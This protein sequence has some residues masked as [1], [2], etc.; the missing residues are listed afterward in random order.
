VPEDSTALPPES[1]SPPI[2]PGELI[3]ERYLV[4]EVLGGGGMGVVYAGTHVLLGTPVAIKLIHPE[5]KDDAEA[6]GRFVNEARAAAA[7]KG[8][9]IA[10]V[11]DAGQLPTGEPYLVMEQ[12]AGVSLDQYLQ[13]RG[14]LPQAEAVAIVLQ[15]CE[16]LAEAHATALVHRDIKPANVFLAERPDGNYSVKVIDFGIAKQRVRTDTPALTNPGKSLGSPW[17]MSP[18]QMLTPASVDPRADIWSLGVLLFELLTA[19]LPFDGESV[20]QVCANVLSTP[21]PSPSE[22]R[23]DVAPELD[24]IVHRC[25][26]KEPQKRFASVNDLAQALL[27]FASV[28]SWNDAG[29]L[30]P[31]AFTDLEPVIEAHVPAYD[32]YT[33]LH[34]SHDVAP[35]PQ[36]RR[37]GWA[38]A[39]TL[40]ALASLFFGGY[41]QYRDPTLVRRAVNATRLTMPWDPT[42]ASA[43][44]PIPLEPTYESPTLLQ[45]MHSSRATPEPPRGEITYT[46]IY[47]PQPRDTSIYIPESRER[48]NV[49]RD[50]DEPPPPSPPSPPSPPR[51][52][53]AKSSV[54][55]RYG[56]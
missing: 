27:P 19:R 54:E 6:V 46:P 31:P 43:E 24:A 23:G 11:F 51:S 35:P 50:S 45:V 41:L 17:Y 2:E 28:G 49:G 55:D 3:A 48:S 30:E 40:V 20:P 13:G 52:Q 15:V 47:I 14:P 39:L 9:H 56:F 22:L 53:G 36:P 44:P 34:S 12:L 21:P 32:S 29:A 8:E 16:G 38:A 1:R 7:L 10:R 33:P 4:G 5:L 42:L 26:E 18:E 37:R 25:L